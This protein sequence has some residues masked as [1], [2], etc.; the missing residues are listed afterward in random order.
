MSMAIYNEIKRIRE[1][2]LDLVRRVESLEQT[3]LEAR[4]KR[5]IITMPSLGNTSQKAANV[6]K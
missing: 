4:K 1:Q 6:Q 2:I 5:E 3:R